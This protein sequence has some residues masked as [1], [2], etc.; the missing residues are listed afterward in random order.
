MKKKRDCSPSVA[1]PQP[2]L[3]LPG[4]AA[5]DTLP[6][7]AEGRGAPAAARR[8]FDAVRREPTSRREAARSAGALERRTAEN[9]SPST[10]PVE[11]RTSHTKTCRMPSIAETTQ[12]VPLPLLLHRPTLQHRCSAGWGRRARAVECARTA[13]QG[14]WSRSTEATTT[15]HCLL[16]LLLLLLLFGPITTETQPKP[17]KEATTVRELQLHSSPSWLQVVVR[18]HRGE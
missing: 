17:K 13:A 10:A 4:C 9:C 16:L 11:R 12:N 14:G 2:F 15:V 1:P 5:P 6:A 3:P 7:L 8:S 18:S